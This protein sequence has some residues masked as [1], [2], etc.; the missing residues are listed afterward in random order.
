MSTVRYSNEVF[1]KTIEREDRYTALMKRILILGA[2]GF[3]G[4][5][6][7]EF[8]LRFP[9]EYEIDAP[10]SSELDLLEQDTVSSYLDKGNYDVVIN[11]AVCNPRRASFKQNAS[12]LECDLRMYYN[13]ERCS[14]K[15]G[16]MLYFGS[17]AEYDKRYPI[18]E[19]AEDDIGK[20]IPANDY[21]LAKYIIGKSIEN[22]RNIY[23]LRIFGLFGKYENWRTTFISGACCKALKGLPITIR[24]NV[25]FDYMYIDDFCRIVKHFVDNDVKYH[26][27]NMSTGKKIDLVSI[28]QTVK[29]ICNADIP[30]YVCSEG[31]ANEY[32]AT[33]KRLLEELCSFDYSDFESSVAALA[34]Y[35]RSIDGDVDIMSLLY[36]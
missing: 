28:A 18:C 2:G 9:N 1:S 12:E 23:N 14:D 29:K 8:F 25:F 31:L 15:F 6:L 21:G 34:E 10:K 13:L 22:S 30:V 5:N 32:T 4:K 27:Y 11:A 35:Y 19:V 24:K 17:G 7:Y 20:S 33:N 36:Q 26:T 16:K 3:A